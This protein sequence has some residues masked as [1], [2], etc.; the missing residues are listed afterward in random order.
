MCVFRDEPGGYPLLARRCP[1]SRW[2]E[3]GL[4]LSC[5][6]WEGVFGNC[7]L[8]GGERESPSGEC[9]V[10]RQSTGRRHAGGPARSSD[11]APVMGRSE[12]AGTSP[13]RRSGVPT[14]P[15]STLLMCPAERFKP[16]TARNWGWPED[17]IGVGVALPLRGWPPSGRGAE[18]A[19]GH[20]LAD[21]AGQGRRGG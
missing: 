18:E 3:P 17:T 7:R 6:T 15:L 8:S 21:C 2:R 4:R 5:G 11:E 10:G 19:R 12:G 1:A 14:R 20:W 16:R 13:G 9:P